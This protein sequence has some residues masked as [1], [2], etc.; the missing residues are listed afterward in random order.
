[1]KCAAEGC[2][3]EL[4]PTKALGRPRKW[5]SDRCRRTQYSRECLDCGAALNG[6]DS[7]GRHLR[8][9]RCAG[10]KHAL[11]A[12]RAEAV[13][14]MWRLRETEGLLNKEIAERVGRSASTIATEFQRLRASGF[15]VPKAPY[16]GAER[17]PSH[18]S[19]RDTQCEVLE[20]ELARLGV[21]PPDRGLPWR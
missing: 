2:T 4:A 14:E 18:A 13:L 21:T 12:G 9:R 20:R 8:C 3:N 7:A 10:L 1:M 16:R 15:S 6:S 11:L 19:Y 5:C 17:G